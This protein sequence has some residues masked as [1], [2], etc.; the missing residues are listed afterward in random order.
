[1]VIFL[2]GTTTFFQ[3]CLTFFQLDEDV[4]NLLIENS[5]RPSISPG[6]ASS[7]F[8]NDFEVML[9]RT[10]EAEAE[11]EDINTKKCIDRSRR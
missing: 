4:K 10:N 7:D 2:E 6:L 5:S 3:F 1:M 9:E 11:V 8:W